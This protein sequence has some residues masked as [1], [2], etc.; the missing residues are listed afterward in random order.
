MFSAP[1]RRHRFCSTFVERLSRDELQLIE[2]VIG[3]HRLKSSP[4]PCGLSPVRA[5]NVLSSPY[6]KLGVGNVHELAYLVGVHQI[7]RLP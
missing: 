6:R 2:P 5:G 1:D 3:G 7:A 4:D